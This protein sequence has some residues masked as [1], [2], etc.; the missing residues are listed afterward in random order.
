M[1]F[2]L[3]IACIGI[4]LS[5]CAPR[6]APAPFTGE[7]QRLAVSSLVSPF[8]RGPLE[9]IVNEEILANG[10]LRAR[11][12]VIPADELERALG[13]PPPQNWSAANFAQLQSLNARLFLSG[14]VALSASSRQ[15]VIRLSSPGGLIG[16][17][18][19]ET[20]PFL[21]AYRQPAQ[22]EDA[23]EVIR[24]ALERLAAG[25]VEAQK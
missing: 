13:G 7:V 24:L 2:A 5:A 16:E 25:L 8:P 15:A 11:V 10:T 17:Y 6:S 20:T 14:R 9:G 1:R 3:L 18:A 4:V 19:A 21:I 12:R 22:A 23:R